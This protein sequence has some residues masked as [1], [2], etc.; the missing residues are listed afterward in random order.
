MNIHRKLF[1]VAYDA[2]S[3]LHSDKSVDLETTLASLEELKERIDF[4][5]EAIKQ[6]IRNRDRW[7]KS[8]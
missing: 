7:K 2:V 4:L 1:A 3:R 6:D 5:V 8:N